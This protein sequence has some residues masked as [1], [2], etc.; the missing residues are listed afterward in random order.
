MIKLPWVER[1][2]PSELDDYVFK[3]PELKEQV[4]AWLKEGSVPSLLF[5]GPAGT[6]KTTLA[7]MLV[8]Q[9]GVD[10]YDVLLANGSKE[11]RKIDWVDKLI[12]FCQTMPFGD[13]KIVLIDEFDYAN[14]Q[15][16]QPALRN[17]M[18]DYSQTVRF[19]AT[20]NYPNRIIPPLKS[21]F[22]EFQIDKL[23]I[24]E[25]TARAATVL[26]EENIEFDL[27]DLDTFVKSAYPDLRK[28][29]NLMQQASVSGTLVVSS[30]AD[31]GTADFKL[32]A[33]D[34]F[35]SGKIKEAR[36]LICSQ[37]TA[38]D[39]ESFFR[40]SYDNLDL[41]SKS[42]EGQ[43]EAILII[44]NALVNAPMVTDQEINVAAMLVELSQIGK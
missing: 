39:M 14:Q 7:K 23:D 8:R 30:V 22:Q 20:C 1:Y 27:D 35:K 6:G 4:E 37:I 3:N 36:Q 21:R 34:L 31:G 10:E 28:C 24:T 16:V 17:L 13:F 38:E 2:R 11:C 12:S 42:P 25:F 33:V 43:D 29:L 5:H 15:S 19:I 26:V 18:E 44:R 40:W 41:W 9:L 32:K